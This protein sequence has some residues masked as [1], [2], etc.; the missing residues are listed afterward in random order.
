MN[1]V[2]L[3]L[4]SIII[5]QNILYMKQINILLLLFFCFFISC[6]E[7]VS[8]QDNEDEVLPPGEELIISHPRLL[9][10]E[11]EEDKIDLLVKGSGHFKKVHDYILDE[12]KKYMNLPPVEYKL[13]GKRLLAVSEEAYRRLYFL[14][15]S[16]R[17]TGEKQYLERA[18]KE[19]LTVCGFK[20]WNPQHFLDIAVM[21]MGVSIGYDWLYKEL[22]ENVRKK[23]KN[24]IIE[25]AIL[26]ASNSKYNW[27]YTSLSNWNQ[28]CNAGLVIGALAIY[29]DEPKLAQETIDKSIKSLNDY[30][31]KVYEPD[32]AY[33]EGY[34][35]WGGGTGMQ[36]IMMASLET[37]LET[38]YKLSENKCFMKSPYFLLLLSTP[39]GFCYNYCDSAPSI[40]LEHAMFWF[41][42]KLQDP[43][44]LFIEYQH[45][46]EFNRYVKNDGT[47]RFLPNVLIFSKNL[48][49]G[50]IKEPNNFFWKSNGVKPIFTYR[51]GWSNKND[52]Y[53]GIV[54]GAANISHGHMDAGS[55]LFEK[56]QVRWAHELGLQSYSTLESKGVD[57]WN[58]SQTG[59]R[60]DVFRL[61]NK[62]HST[63]IVND[64]RH[65]VDGAPQII[66]TF[67]TDE[68][69]GAEID[70]SSLFPNSLNKA[71]RKVILNKDDDL[72]I[73]DKITT[74]SKTDNIRWQMVTQSEAKL[75]GNKIILTKN[76]HQMNLFVETNP[77]LQIKMKI[78]GNSHVDTD[79]LHEYDHDNP[80]TCRVGFIIEDVEANSNY[81]FKVSL[82]TER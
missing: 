25:K 12:S 79:E 20:D 66:Q 44:L 23:V 18:E 40:K 21:V 33:P 71:V 51:S 78:W 58:Y 14:S 57:L 43:S 73:T 62:G 3:S 15:Y 31:M 38:D 9:L 36:V 70:L 6:N 41:A 34:T 37:A 22:S 10:K 48:D 1:E 61:S 82:V 55:F 32:G 27:F 4:R 60:W 39:T 54:G 67:Q 72:I 76:G 52:A 45:L 29:E 81:Q 2:I 8:E 59:Q 13:E 26:P 30:G 47:D 19:I 35:Y 7:T 80:G 5:I 42:D 28:I 46:E 53:L 50:T 64:E 74:N 75:E 24:A 69:K 49:L 65:Y 17:M 68:E 77:D 56:N 16:Y 11:G 63:L